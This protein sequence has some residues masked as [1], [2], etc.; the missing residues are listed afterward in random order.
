MVV[1]R[2]YL[3]QLRADPTFKRACGCLLEAGADLMSQP[4]VSRLE[5]T[6]GLGDPIQ[7]WRGLVNV[8]C[9]SSA[10]PFRAVTL[11][12]EETCDVVHSYQQLSL[13]NPHH[14]TR[15]FFLIE[16]YDTATS[17]PV[18]MILRASKTG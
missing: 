18:A 3:D 7:L 10:I 16:V 4:T 5:N 12:I 15:C 14:D 6:P 1:A 17:R 13:F 8:C 9:T 11:D 2:G